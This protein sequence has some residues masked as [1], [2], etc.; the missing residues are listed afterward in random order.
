MKYQ[1]EICNGFDR[2]A[3]KARDNYCNLMFTMA[4]DLV[5]KKIYLAHKDGMKYPSNMNVRY[6]VVTGGVVTYKYQLMDLAKHIRLALE[7][8]D[9]NDCSED[10]LSIIDDLVNHEIE[11]WEERWWR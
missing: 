10:Q 3:I 6:Y 2:D 9:E 7:E 11:A 8:Y 1:F 5:E 4:V